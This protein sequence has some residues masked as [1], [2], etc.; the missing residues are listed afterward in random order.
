[1][2]LIGVSLALDQ[3]LQILNGQRGVRLEELDRVPEL[4]RSVR[5]LDHHVEARANRFHVTFA[6]IIGGAEL[7]GLDRDVQHVLAAVVRTLLRINL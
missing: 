7:G 4:G 1:M 3:P 2:A 6:L 5:L